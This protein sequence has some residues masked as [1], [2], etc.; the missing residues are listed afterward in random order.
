MLFTAIFWKE[1][2]ERAI[3]TLAQTF[4]AL[5]A[6]ETFN[7][8]NIDWPNM[9]GVAGAAA[10]LS[11]ATSIVSASITKRPSPSLVKEGEGTDA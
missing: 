3:K 7:L 5:D 4:L 8:L 1:A 2:T 10:V 11:Y 9:L 6:G